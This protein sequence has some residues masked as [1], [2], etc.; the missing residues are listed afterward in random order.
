MR[1]HC[2]VVSKNTHPYHFLVVLISYSFGTVSAAA[3]GSASIL[4][5]SWAYIKLMGPVGLRRASEVPGLSSVCVCVCV[6]VCVYV[7]VRVCACAC[8]CV[9]VRVRACEYSTYFCSLW[10]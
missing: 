3:W 5:I 10:G 4:P 8:V 2:R 1:F 7:Y 6:C 9:C